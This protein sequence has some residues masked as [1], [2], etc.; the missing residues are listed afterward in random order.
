MNNETEKKVKNTSNVSKSEPEK[1][2]GQN[3]CPKCG[4]TEIS[5]IPQTDKLRCNFCRHE[6]KIEKAEQNDAK[7]L[8]GT[9]ISSGASD[10]QADASNIITLKCQ[11]CGAEVVIDTN[12]ALQGKCHWCRNV[13]SLNSQ[14]PNGAV[15]DMVLP[16]FISKE[17]ARKAIEDFVKS[18]SFFANT[19]FKKEFTTEN[20]NGV[21]FPYM[22][23]D[24]N[25]HCELKGE[26]EH[27]LKEYNRGSSE[28]PDKRYDA[29]AYH[30]ERTFDIA[31]DD[32]TIESS[33]DKLDVTND[34]NTNNVINAIMPFDIVNCVKWDANYLKGYTS[35]KRD[36]NV[37][38]IKPILVEQSKD[39]S[40]FACN[41]SLSF[42]NRG[43]RW[44]EEKIDIKGEDWKS[45]LLP[46]WLYSY[47][48]IKNNKKL[49]HYVAVNARTKEVMGSVPLNKTKLLFVSILVEILCIFLYINVEIDGYEIVF[50]LPGLLFYYIMYSRYRN[51]E[52]RHEY[53]NETKKEVS[54][55]TQ[56][57][58]H[59]EKR[60]GLRNREIV[61]C[62]NRSVFGKVPNKVDELLKKIQ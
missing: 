4:S 28:H 44:D 48:E 3:K 13:L 21:Y 39:I 24:V 29:D 60:K 19:K 55:M 23:V 54:N 11:S 57:D 20:I 41:E 49:L 47:I 30:V 27:L 42:Y 14:V 40:K 6:F 37:A 2:H 56:V 9:T 26:G 31:I 7:N 18:R 33:K 1:E 15:P 38:E 45:A 34:N 16:F 58:T 61:G 51:K 12:D 8:K 5:N 62:N 22:V 10:I 43:V 50:L 25:A 17:D 59:I 52:A 53:E 36:A 46:V 35:E 32:L